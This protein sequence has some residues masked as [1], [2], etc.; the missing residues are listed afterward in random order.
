MSSRVFELLCVHSHSAAR[1]EAGTDQSSG[2]QTIL[3]DLETLFSLLSLP[4]ASPPMRRVPLAPREYSKLGPNPA[5][6]TG[7][8]AHLFVPLLHSTSS[9]MKD[10]FVVLVL[11]D[12][13][14]RA[15]LIRTVE[16]SDGMGSWMEIGEVG[17]IGGPSAKGKER[18]DGDSAEVTVS[19]TNLGYEVKAETL[20]SLW[21]H[22]VCVALS[23]S[24]LY[25]A[26]LTAATQTPRCALRGGTATALATNPL[27]PCPVFDRLD[28]G[29]LSSIR[30]A[31][32]GA[33]CRCAGFEPACTA[34]SFEDC[35]RR[36]SGIV[37]CWRG[38]ASP[39]A[40]RTHL[41]RT[42]RALTHF[43][44][45]TTL[46]IRLRPSLG[47]SLLSP[48][49]KLP[50]NVLFNPSSGVLILAI[51]DDLDDAVER[52]LRFVYPSRML[53]L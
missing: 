53:R 43:G 24:H 37:C 49:T 41:P 39:S 10:W 33:I 20:R 47:S 8:A 19:G 32:K 14:V 22:C 50:P 52:L 46:H 42:S 36:R 11:F 5:A 9:S 23:R 16:K 18:A 7:R 35:G 40:L 2:L 6:L 12:E 27:P 34:G 4:L 31:A 21:W 45:Q 15:A 29:A 44:G 38:R 17:W 3:D 48:S 13:G 26:R 1:A 51:E 25:V 28:V 30:Q